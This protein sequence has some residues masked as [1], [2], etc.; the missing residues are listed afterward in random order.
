MSESPRFVYSFD[1][2]GAQGSAL[3]VALLGSKGA[4]LHE[5][6]R[7]GLPVPPGFTI[8]TEA[9]S[10][11]FAN[12]RALIEP[13]QAQVEAALKRLETIT[14]AT[15]GSEHRPLVLS[16]RGGAAESMPGALDSVLNVGLSAAATQALAR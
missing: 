5:I 11:Y 15:L 12:N 14:G 16:V 4:Y 8:T 7:L 1:A 13:L 6:T 10:S 2:L 9:C 3:D